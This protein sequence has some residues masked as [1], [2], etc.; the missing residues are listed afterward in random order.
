MLWG[1]VTTNHG[2]DGMH[3]TYAGG[4]K[5]RVVLSTQELGNLIGILYISSAG[6]TLSEENQRIARE[7]CD[8][9]DITRSLTRDAKD[10]G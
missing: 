3:V 4:H 2:E 1:R 9:L 7:L 6:R 8:A 10:Q 5:L